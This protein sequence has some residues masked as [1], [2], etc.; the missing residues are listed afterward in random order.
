MHQLVVV[1]D[2]GPHV[3]HRG[4]RF[5]LDV[6]ELARVLGKRAALGDDEHHGVAHETHHVVG[7]WAGA[8]WARVQRFL[9]GGSR[10]VVEGVDR[11]DP[12][13]SRRLGGVE[14]RDRRTRVRAPHERDV[15]H[16]GKND[17]VGVA[18]APGEETRVF[19]PRDARTDESAGFYLDESGRVRG[20]LLGL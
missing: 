15:Q 2:R 14:V 1:V 19:L 10:E 13:H 11:E 9:V 20:M 17:V 6:D 12:E 16:A 7:K 3:D 5:V 18:P 4:A 8:E